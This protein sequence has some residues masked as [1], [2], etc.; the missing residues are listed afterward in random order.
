MKR[1]ELKYLLL[2]NDI[3]IAYLQETKLNN[4]Q[5]QINGYITIR[6]DCGDRAER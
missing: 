1:E 5:L 4:I 2:S 6:K 3:D